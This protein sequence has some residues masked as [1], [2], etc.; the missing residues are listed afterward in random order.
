L[1]LTYAYF[2]TPENI[3]TTLEIRREQLE[4]DNRRVVR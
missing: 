4:D 2:L 3:R 1:S